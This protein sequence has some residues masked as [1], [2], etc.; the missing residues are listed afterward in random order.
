M[1]VGTGPTHDH[2][3]GAGNNG[4]HI[5]NVVSSRTTSTAARL[6]AKIKIECNKSTG[7]GELE[8]FLL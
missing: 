7:G 8:L 6:I 5:H 4:I 3:L 2:T 1:H